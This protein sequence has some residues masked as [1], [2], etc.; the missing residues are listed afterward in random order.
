MGQRDGAFKSLFYFALRRPSGVVL[1]V[2]FELLPEAALG[3]PAWAG[4]LGDATDRR[5]V[6]PVDL[7]AGL[8][9]D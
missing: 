8:P 2:P 9:I 7:V 1:G 3:R 4:F 6:G 5:S